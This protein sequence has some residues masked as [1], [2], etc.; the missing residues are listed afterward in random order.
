MR[1]GIF[2]PRR[3]RRFSLNME[4]LGETLRHLGHE[5]VLVCRGADEADCRIP[6]RVASEADEQATGFWEALGL[7]GVIAFAGLGSAEAV[8]AMRAS[9]AFVVSRGDT[10]GQLGVRVFP[11]AAWLRMVDPARG[12]VDFLKRARHFL[13]CWRIHYRELDQPNLAGIEAA[14]AVVV[15]TEAAR[16]NLSRFLSHYGRAEWLAKVHVVP[17]PVAPDFESGNPL[18]DP[19]PAILCVGRWHD[20]QKNAP[21]LRRTLRRLRDVRAVVAGSG[22]AFF[23]GLP[24]VEVRESIP[25]AE[26]PAAFDR[27]RILLSASRFEGHPISGLEAV[28]RGRT[29]VA[30]PLP[31]FVDIVQDGR[32]G[33]LAGS[34]SARALAAAVRTELAAWDGGRRAPAAIAAHWRPRVSHR[35]VVQSLLALIPE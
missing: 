28:C 34:H 6:L 35:T 17:H 25:N 7:R 33:T 2:L 10:D 3:W 18:P 19:G 11:R 24:Q 23:S 16:A 20:D 27:C 1:I 5:P 13:N 26:M 8:R 30:P 12:P 32:F 31:G 4:E 14:D 29:V 22:A 21:L 15:E 9:G